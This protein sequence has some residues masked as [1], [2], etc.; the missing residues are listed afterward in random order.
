M[1]PYETPSSTHTAPPQGAFGK[2]DRSHTDPTQPVPP[3]AVAHALEQGIAFLASV[4]ETD[5]SWCG[6]YGGPMFLLPMYIA[7]TAICERP[8][9]A[10]ERAEMIRYIL[11]AQNTDGGIGIHAEA[12]ESMMF[13]SVLSYVALRL[14]DES[15]DREEI[16]RMRRWIREHG[17]ALAAASWAKWI[18]CV[19]HLYEYDGLHPILPELYLLPPQ[20]PIHPGHLWCHARQ[21]Y[22]PMAYLYGKKAKID[23]NERIQALRNEIYTQPYATIRFQ[24]HR[25][26]LCPT[27]RSYGL[28]PLAS[29]ANAAMGLFERW[30]SPTLRARALAEVKRH[31]DHEDQSTHF[32]RIGPVN[33]V[34]NTLVHHFEDPQGAALVQ[35]WETLPAYLW[36]GHDGLKMNGYNSCKLWDTAFTV[37]AIQATPLAE[38]PTAQDALSHAYRLHQKQPSARRCARKR[39]L[40]S[41]RKPRRLAFQ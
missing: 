38:T 24:D 31:I 4:Q 11:S 21:V 10:T 29:L 33:A 30:N 12:E 35:S 32:I 28:S 39:S 40:F 23:A 41:P 8:P 3:Q 9:S 19:L 17:G 18:L 27:D 36:Q 2:D 16:V 15:P 13:T 34:L 25:D 6:D 37:Q 20:A 1:S 22:L 5:G 14:L 7:A 26:T